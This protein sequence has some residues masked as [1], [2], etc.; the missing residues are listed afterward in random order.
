MDRTV[1]KTLSFYA[2]FASWAKVES[3]FTPHLIFSLEAGRNVGHG[4]LAISVDNI[5]NH[6]YAVN[7]AGALTGAEYGQARTLGLKDTLNF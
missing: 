3:Q 4:Q 1:S 6:P 2:H 5:L 7:L